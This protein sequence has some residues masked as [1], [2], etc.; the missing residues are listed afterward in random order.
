[1]GG[2]IGMGSACKPM[3]VL[4]QCMTKFTT[5]KTIKLLK[6]KKKKHR[7]LKKKNLFNHLAVLDLICSLW[8]LLP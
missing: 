5:N 3:P 7:G 8:D 2:G 6:K 1:M 4:F